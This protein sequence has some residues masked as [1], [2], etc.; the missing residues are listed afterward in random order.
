[1]AVEKEHF[2]HLARPLAPTM[3]FASSAPLTVNIQPQ[4]CLPTTH[5]HLAMAWHGVCRPNAAVCHG[6]VLHA[7]I[8]TYL[9]TYIAL[10]ASGY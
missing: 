9:H 1:M 6:L 10:A 5:P 2:V 4:V 7:S 8:H 3:G